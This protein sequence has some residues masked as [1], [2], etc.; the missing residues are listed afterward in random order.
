MR[1]LHIA[2]AHL[3]TPFY[4][5]TGALR[6]KLQRACR[7]A[8]SSAV[9][10]AIQREVHAFLI[11]GDLF[12]NDRL[13][14]ST[15]GFLFKAL[16]RLNESG[17]P[18]FYATGNHDPGQAKYRTQQLE[19]P[20]NVYLFA[21][22]VPETV[23]IVDHEGNQVGW[24]TAAGHNTSQEG[25]NLA[26]Q[27]RPA[28]SVLPH[29]AM[30]HTQIVSAKGAEQHG[31]YA[32]C[33]RGDLTGPGFDYWALGHVH[34]RQKVFEDVPAW[35]P[36]NLQGR[37]PKE[38]G[39][40][41]ALY[42]ELER[43]GIPQMEFI[44]LAPVVWDWVELRCPEGPTTFA[45]LVSGLADKI[46]RV[47][48]LADGREH[49]VRIDLTGESPLADRINDVENLRELTALIQDE[50]DVSWLEIRPRGLVR[51]VQFEQYEGSA[52][53][54]GEFLGLLKELLKDDTLLEQIRPADLARTDIQD[55]RKY[56]R[57]LLP[58]M[59]REAAALLIPE[60]E[61]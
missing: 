47:T 49:L 55:A 56:L 30:L 18:V 43:H 29:V 45:S 40:K 35:Y 20:D 6:R 58:G 53:V 41:G 10:V 39:P 59:D 32:P 31:R 33:T 34:L 19:W 57:G 24:L 26:A 11:A 42:I 38:T 14:F 60:G 23:P 44:P 25:S 21:S 22:G 17:I 61:R 54:L 3:D 36:G 51:P 16:G 7:Q 27:F 48:D 37:N 52:T 13:S 28:K 1:I 4:G 2:D 46:R 5:R 9:D 8:F 12:D 50:I 15:E